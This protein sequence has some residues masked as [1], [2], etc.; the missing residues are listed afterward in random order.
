M[1]CFIATKT[2]TIIRKGE[3][4]EFS[5]SNIMKNKKRVFFLLEAS[6]LFGKTA[7]VRFGSILPPSSQ[8]LSDF[9]NHTKLEFLTAVPE[10]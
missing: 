10:F 3:F 1:F 4:L 9:V 5:Q 6:K 8:S 7:D 2:W